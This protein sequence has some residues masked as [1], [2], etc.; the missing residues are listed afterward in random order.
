MLTR[1]INSRTFGKLGPYNQVQS[2]LYRS[3]SGRVYIMGQGRV[4]GKGEGHLFLD[5]MCDRFGYQIPV[6]TIILCDDV[7]GLPSLPLEGNH[8]FPPL[9]QEIV[10]Y[11]LDIARMIGMPREVVFR[12][13]DVIE[14]QFCQTAAGIFHSMLAVFDSTDEYYRDVFLQ[15]LHRVASSVMRDDSLVYHAVHGY[16]TLEPIAILIQKL[17]G[18]YWL[19][20]FQDSSF[21]PHLAG[22]MNTATPGLIKFSSV[23]GLGETAVGPAGAGDFIVYDDQG[24]E[25]LDIDGN[26]TESMFFSNGGTTSISTGN[27]SFRQYGSA[28]L[29][30]SRVP[31]EALLPV[32]KQ[33]QAEVGQPLDFEWAWV[34]GE[35]VYLLQIRPLRQK[36]AFFPRPEVASQNVL[37]NTEWAMGQGSTTVSQLIVVD[38]RQARECFWGDILVDM[39]KQYPGSLLLFLVD[40]QNAGY[41][42]G[43]STV[44]RSK[45]VVIAN[46]SARSREHG[47][48][49]QHLAL[50]LHDEGRILL[51]TEGYQIGD[52]LMGQ[53]EL[54]E[55]KND[56]FGQGATVKV[57]QLR[58]PITVAADDEHAWGMIF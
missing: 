2:G 26:R 33:L 22:I 14:D 5:A 6:P 53:G 56:L 16:Q 47:S 11:V 58:Q 23:L 30:N 42:I 44:A 45:A 51:Y 55:E 54:L 49:L 18:S 9:D 24:E 43:Y 1:E 38:Q 19:Q 20:G 10:A 29:C 17:V 31:M 3:Q 8:Q 13:S 27:L 21:G 52:K 28:R 41:G 4:G 15:K 7:F 36:L 48:G 40:E 12:S 50:N 35:P 46:N 37:L 34:K 57:F 39:N 25:I 32:A